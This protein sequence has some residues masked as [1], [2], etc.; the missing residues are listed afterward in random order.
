M[1]MEDFVDIIDY[2]GLYKINKNGDV[3][4]CK[5]KKLRKNSMVDGYKRVGLSKNNVEK[6][7]LVHRLIAQHFIPNADNK[8]F[9]D[10]IN[11]IRT[12][13]RIENLRWVSR[14]ENAQNITKP[15]TNISGYKNISS[16]TDKVYG[17][18]YWS[19]KINY[20]NNIYHKTFNKTKYTL[21]EVIEIR[22]QKYIELGLEK[23][24]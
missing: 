21:E 13:N 11:H 22:N 12:D 15:I 16:R 6:K 17:R 7:Y 19:I 14:C 2:E 8:P 24:D 5:Y 3:W 9:I 23:Y 18:E 20:N 1:D 4:I 10:H